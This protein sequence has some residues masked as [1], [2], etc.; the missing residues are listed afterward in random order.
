MPES[1]TVTLEG[2]PCNGRVCKFSENTERKTV[3]IQSLPLKPGAAAGL[4]IYRRV[5]GSNPLVF[6]HEEEGAPL[7][8]EK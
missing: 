7:S 1:I 2:G 4:H 8:K 5:E 6:R 3:R